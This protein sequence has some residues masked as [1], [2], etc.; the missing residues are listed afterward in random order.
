M[1]N[2]DIDKLIDSAFTKDRANIPQLPSELDDTL[3]SQLKN[4]NSTGTSAMKFAKRSF[5]SNG[6]FKLTIGVFGAATIGITVY[7]FFFI[8]GETAAPLQHSES[9]FAPK[10][11]L[12]KGKNDTMVRIQDQGMKNTIITPVRSGKE[13]DTGSL[14]RQMH[15]NDLLPSEKKELKKDEINLPIEE[16]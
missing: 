11:T 4:R 12:K 15:S 14:R 9:I 13:S 1:K 5:L 3:L 7:F 16:K 6:I 2:N 10:D 8:S